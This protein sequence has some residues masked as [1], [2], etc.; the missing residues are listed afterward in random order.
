MTDTANT[1]SGRPGLDALLVYGG[2]GVRATGMGIL[3]VLIAIYHLLHERILARIAAKGFVLRVA[4]GAML[5]FNGWL[6]T[7]L[8]LN[9]GRLFFELDT[10]RQTSQPV[11]PKFAAPGQDRQGRTV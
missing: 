11:S 10:H 6:R 7:A 2:R 4:A 3:A 9:L 5:S 1:P 8:G